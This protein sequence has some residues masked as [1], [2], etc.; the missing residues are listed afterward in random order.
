MQAVVDQL[1]HHLRAAAVE[2]HGVD[3]GRAGLGRGLQLGAH[4][5]G[6]HGAAAAAGHG[7]HFR[8]QLG[9]LGHQPGLRVAARIGVVQAVDVGGDEQHVGIDQGRDDRRQVVVVAQL[10]LVHRDGVVLVDHRQRAQRQQLLEG[11]AGVEVAAAVAQVV[12]GQ[13]HLRH[14]ALEE[15]LPQLDQACLAQRGQRL[16]LGDGGAGLGRARQDGAAGGDRAGGHDHHLAPGQHRG[17]HELCQAQGEARR[18]PAA[19]GG[20]QAA[21]DLQHGTAPGRQRLQV[22]GQGRVAHARPLPRAAR[23]HSR[24]SRL[25]LPV[26]ASGSAAATAWASPR[27]ASP[28]ST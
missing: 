22:Q 3:A 16:A 21:A 10:E 26:S 19:I 14:R 7:Q 5:A 18:Q 28:R 13:Q 9:H 27:L 24:A 23:V 17:G 12:V 20:Q 11:G 15:A 2:Q 4:A 1:A 8:G 6:A 25:E